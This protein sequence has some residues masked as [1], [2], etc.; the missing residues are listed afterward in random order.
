MS[1][2]TRSLINLLHNCNFL[3]KLYLHHNNIE[4]LLNSTSNSCYICN[5]CWKAILT[6]HKFYLKVESV[7]SLPNNVVVKVENDPLD[8]HV[9]ESNAQIKNE[10]NNILNITNIVDSSNMDIICAE[11]L[12]IQNSSLL[13]LNSFKYDESI[14]NDPPSVPQELEKVTYVKKKLTLT[15][16]LKVNMKKNRTY[17][18]KERR[19]LRSNR[20]MDIKIK[21]K[22]K[23]EIDV[24]QEITAESLQILP[25]TISCSES[26]SQSN[27]SSK[28]S[29]KTTIRDKVDEFIVSNMNLCCSFCNVELQSF[30]QLK[31]HYRTEH[32]SRGFATCCGKQFLKRC[33]LVDHINVHINP[34]HFKCKHCGKIFSSRRSLESHIKLHERGR[35]RIYECKECH[36]S[37]F[38]HPVYMRHLTLHVPEELRNINC[39]QCKKS[40]ATEYMMTQHLNNVHLNLH[41]KMCELCGK[42]IRG[43]EAL[44]QH[45]ETHSGK[46]APIQCN[47]CGMT[48]TTKYGLI[49]HKKV[50]HSEENQ[51]P[52]TCEICSKVSPS[53][54]AH[55]RHMRYMHKTERKFACTLCDKAF[56]TSFTLREHMTTHIGGAL[57]TCTHCTKT[58]NS[59]ANM[60]A[61]RKKIH[62]NEWE[63][64]NSEKCIS[65]STSTVPLLTDIK[66]EN[67]S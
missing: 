1:S 24:E 13:E 56:K 37:Y 10:E 8:A 66:A 3:L 16:S 64:M 12:N 5:K 41:T 35:E 29:S 17:S 65:K 54:F 22:E 58:F 53:V 38:S 6:F 2:R 14:E 50:M 9:E 48:L 33:L 52:K 36:K 51:I 39:P 49:R 32:K 34:Q 27:I 7:H 30:A 55:E 45:M 60:Y 28:L 44:R 23:Q 42:S 4:E 62:R 20:K 67:I 25:E 15:S 11:P 31:F 47:E 46:T 21:E 57:Y 59:K 19:I 26:S 18:K 40:F 61:H 63:K 43:N